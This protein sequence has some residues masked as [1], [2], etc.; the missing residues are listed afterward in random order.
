MKK[1]IANV[2]FY[3]FN[4]E[5]NYMQQACIFYADGTVKNTT[6]EEGIEAAN[7]IAKEENIKTK[8]A[9][10]DLLNKKRIYTLTGKDFERRFK[11]FLGNNYNPKTTTDNKK[12]DPTRNGTSTKTQTSPNYSTPTDH[13]NT[14]SS[15]TKSS[16]S[17][18]SQKVLTDS[19]S[20]IPPIATTT[21]NKRKKKRNWFQRVKDKFAN[22]RKNKKKNKKKGGVGSWFKRTW[23]KI[24]AGALAVVMFFTGGFFLG[25]KSQDH[26]IAE[27]PKT[28]ISS[29]GSAKS[30]E[31]EAQDLAY[32]KLLSQTTNSVQSATMQR[33]SENLDSFNRDFSNEYLEKNKNIKAALTWDEMMAL[34]LAYNTYTKE[35]IKIM[36]NGA[37]IDST[38]MSSAYK[39]ATLQLM[40]AYVISTREKP[41]PLAQFI[42]NQK[43][44][45]FVEKYNNLFYKCKETT[46]NDQ[47]KAINAFYEE[48]YKDFPIDEQIREEGISHSEGRNLVEPYKA[49]I[50][51]IVA[52][53]EIMFQNNDKIDHT[54]SDKAIAYFNDIGLCNLVDEQFKRVE[55]I[56]LSSETDKTLPLYEDFRKTKISELGYEGNYS[57]SDEDRDLSQLDAFQKWVNGHFVIVNGI[58]TGE[59]V[60]NTTSSYTTNESTVTKTETTSKT[61]TDRSEAVEQAGEQAVKNAENAANE[62][63]NSENKVNKENAEQQ[64]EQNRQEM[65]AVESAKTDKLEDEVVTSDKELQDMLDSANNSN[66]QTNENDFG[67]HGVIFAPEYSDENGNLSDSVGNITTDGSGAVDSNDPLPDPNKTGA[68]FDGVI[69]GTAEETLPSQNTSGQEIY[70]YEETYSEPV[71]NEEIVDQYIASLSSQPSETGYQ[72]TKK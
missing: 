47:I 54:L 23:K 72:Y 64:A 21:T 17:S 24:T 4:G 14:T 25:K 28:T 45:K 5:H 46:G 16:N 30:K 11:E 44:R 48:L 55:T 69:S 31:I 38:T 57:V 1:Q 52:A 43:E 56:T 34:N 33:Q 13:N 2:V 22:R 63:I 40:G 51:P 36:F 32:G 70:E 67:D 26:N 8:D 42:T 29:A 62:K 18:R 15:G 61:A 9:L 59:F 35:Q 20:N 58:N 6:I 12:T 3:K 65:Q 41:V 39:N 66:N 71:T 49:A 60:A 68:I 50:T 19:S 27:N 37:E 53:T 10:A 7:I